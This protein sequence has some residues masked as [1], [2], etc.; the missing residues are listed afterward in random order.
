[1]INIGPILSIIKLM[2]ASPE[3]TSQ[4][5]PEQL[6]PPCDA[7]PVVPGRHLQFLLEVSRGGVDRCLASPC[8]SSAPANHSGQVVPEHGDSQLAVLGQVGPE[9]HSQQGARLGLRYSRGKTERLDEGIIDGRT[10][11]LQQHDVIQSQGEGSVVVIRVNL[12]LVHTNVLT[13]VY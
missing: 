10:G 11:E 9:H 1:M 6:L 4:V 3:F 13:T 2:K 8:G 5:D 12:G 7:V